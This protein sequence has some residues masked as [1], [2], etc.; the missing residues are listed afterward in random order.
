MKLAVLLSGP[1]RGSNFR[2]LLESFGAGGPV[3]VSLL[4]STRPGVPALEI[5]RAGGVRAEVVPWRRAE[6]RG[7]AEEALNRLFSKEAPDLIVLA[8]FL[9]QL[10]PDFVRSWWG[11]V[12]NIHPSLLPAFPGLHPQRQALQ[13][14]AAVTGCTVHYVDA[15]LDHG[16][17]ILQK[18]LPI[19]PGEQESEL[20]ERI[21]C[22]E[23]EALPQAVRM[24]RGGA[25]F[26]EPS[27][28]A[29]LAEF[30]AQFAGLPAAWDRAGLSPAQRQQAVRLARLLRDPFP[31]LVGLCLRG[32]V[33]QELDWIRELDRCLLAFA[34]L[35]PLEERRLDWARAQRLAEGGCGRLSDLGRSWLD[36]W[37]GEW[38]LTRW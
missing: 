4:V 7:P 2:A 1:G 16:E 8:G 22:L 28:A 30:G 36:R 26:P 6:D 32:E 5:A 20:S 19:R 29:G 10:S 25:R 17:V 14:G 12:I 15:Q 34:E 37:S 23:H 21:L 24:I 9:R 11:R 31:D 35:R 18:A 13:A 38:A 3:Q 33:T 27:A